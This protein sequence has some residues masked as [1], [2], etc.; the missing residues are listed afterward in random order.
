MFVELRELLRSGAILVSYF[1][2]GSLA[3][4]SDTGFKRFYEKASDT[5]H[6]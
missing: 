5:R 1:T 2:G 6:L 3:V 4:I